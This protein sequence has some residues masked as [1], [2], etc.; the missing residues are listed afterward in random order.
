MYGKRTPRCIGL[1]QAQVTSSPDYV[2][3]FR[4]RLLEKSFCGKKSSSITK[5]ENIGKGGQTKKCRPTQIRAQFPKEVEIND[6]HQ[7]REK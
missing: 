6:R 1:V 5:K 3:K 4:N 7:K 2:T